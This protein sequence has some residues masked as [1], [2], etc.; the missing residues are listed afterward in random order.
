MVEPR[1]NNAQT[2]QRKCG[3]V[4]RA[5]EARGAEDDFMNLVRCLPRAATRRRL[6]E[7]P[8]P[9]EA[10]RCGVRGHL[11]PDTRAALGGS[12][13]EAS[14]PPKDFRRA[15]R[16]AAGQDRKQESSSR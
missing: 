13:N 3:M 5:G 6:A 15:F 10:T 8:R 2:S 12:T 16:A 11:L 7:A 9:F 14:G 4:N 1:N